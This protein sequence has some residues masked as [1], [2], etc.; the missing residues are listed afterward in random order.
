[1]H[2]L[3]LSEPVERTIKPRVACLDRIGLHVVASPHRIQRR[4]HRTK[5][6]LNLLLS[7]GVSERIKIGRDE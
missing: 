6:L 1:L 5:G 7:T 2:L 3:V 4:L